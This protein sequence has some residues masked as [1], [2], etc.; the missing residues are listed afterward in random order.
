MQAKK[1]GRPEG[2]PR[3]DSQTAY[4]IDSLLMRVAQLPMLP[5]VPPH[6]PL[7]VDGFAAGKYCAYVHVCSTLSDEI[8]TALSQ[9]ILFC[10][11][12]IS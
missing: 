11:L 8:Q 1:R 6:V 3:T 9:V 12:G 10:G 7:N 4:L 5:R 2:R